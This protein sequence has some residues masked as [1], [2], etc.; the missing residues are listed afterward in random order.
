MLISAEFCC[1]MKKEVIILILNVS[2]FD[3]KD[4]F[5]CG[6]CFRWN[7]NPDGSYTGIAF[8]KVLNVKKEDNKFVLS[9]NSALWEDYFDLNTDYNNIM[10]TLS[11]DDIMTE[12]INKSSGI[13][14][15]RQEFSETVISFI[16]SQNNNIPRIK[17]IIENLCK[18]FGTELENEYFSFPEADTLASLSPDDLKFLKAGYRDSYI[19]DAAQN[20]YLK[21][22]NMDIIKNAP[23]EEARAEISKIK[24]IGPKVADCILLFG[25]ARTEVFPTDVWMKKVLTAFYGF[26]TLTPKEI[27][28]FAYQK[29]GA[30]AGYAQQY[31]FNLARVNKI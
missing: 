30:L 16:I 10:K 31:L 18:N 3:L 21:K 22:L 20:I 17:S 19:I 28:N 7:E 13:R 27:N 29:F 5:E 2:P 1:K 26:E 25:A 14:I 9:D 24:G 23:I 11:I 12:A 4:T 15:L 6:Q 8:G